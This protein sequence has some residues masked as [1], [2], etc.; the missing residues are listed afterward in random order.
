[1]TDLTKILASL[2]PGDVVEA[3]TQRSTTGEFMITGIVWATESGTLCVGTLALHH[4][5]TIRVI[6]CAPQPPTV[7]T[8]AKATNQAFKDWKSPEDAAYDERK[9]IKDFVESPSVAPGADGASLWLTN[10]RGAGS[11]IDAL[12]DMV[13]QQERRYQSLPAGGW[14]LCRDCGGS[15]KSGWLGAHDGL[16]ALLVMME[17]RLSPPDVTAVAVE[18]RECGC[19]RRNIDCE[20]PTCPRFIPEASEQGK[21]D[22]LDK[23]VAVVGAMPTAFWINA[24]ADEAQAHKR[25]VHDAIE[26]LRGGP[27]AD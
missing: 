21:Q 4:A 24:N 12:D 27:H 6:S 2:R 11:P 9:A 14:F 25:Y 5:L 22:A 18:A 15:V 3:T 16:H 26:A 7:T 13:T 17:E 20:H 19:P 8:T 23:V 10:A 1:M